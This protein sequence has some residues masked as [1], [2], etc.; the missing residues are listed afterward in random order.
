MKGFIYR[1]P[2]SKDS[3]V[4]NVEEIAAEMNE[5]INKVRHI[6]KI[7]QD[8][9]SLE[10]SV[11]DDDEDSTLEDFIED[12]K[13]VTPDKSAAL[14]LLKDYVKEKTTHKRV[15]EGKAGKGLT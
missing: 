8:T 15:V 4:L 13:N 12:V 1:Y 9:I 7:S 3:L 11:G 10:T 2:A 6:I 5:E 14:E